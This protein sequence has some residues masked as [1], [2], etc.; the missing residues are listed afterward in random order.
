[1][2]DNPSGGVW[3]LRTHKREKEKR[4]E[5]EINF[6]QGGRKRKDGKKY[7]VLFG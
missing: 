7:Q 2:D 4:R 1:M 5:R 3:A 6:L